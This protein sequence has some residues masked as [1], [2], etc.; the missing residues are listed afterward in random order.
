MMKSWKPMAAAFSL[1]LAL[2]VTAGCGG[3]PAADAVSSGSASQGA[4]TDGQAVTVKL[5]ADTT[6][7]PFEMQ[8]NGE[9]TGFDIDLMK[10]IAQK[11]NFA[12]KISTMN[13]TGLI[14]AV[15]T[16]QADVG[17][18]G[19]TI[20]KSRMKAVNFSNAYY[21]S[22]L[23][24]LVKKSDAGSIR[25][26]ADLKG[27]TIATKK[28][29][30]SVDKAKEVE[31]A[32]IRQFDNID[33]AYNELLNGGAQAVIFDNPVNS[34]FASTHADQVTI[35]GG[36]L[37]GE[38]YGIAVNKDQTELLKKINEG[39]A[40]LRKDGTYDKLYKQYFGDDTIGK[41]LDDIAPDKAA[42]DE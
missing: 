7:P 18:A 35:T 31:G 8:K 32:K 34:N 39:L 12:L 4:G 33:D 30:S 36:L 28:G 16:G 13:F 40:Q 23:S 19:I 27:K 42:L 10:A 1:V 37:S 20:K 14:P 15:Q 22:G 3:K 21:K 6:F 24:I 41:V 38:Y 26:L 9:V 25:G 17:V 29:T 2:A 5:A 11:E